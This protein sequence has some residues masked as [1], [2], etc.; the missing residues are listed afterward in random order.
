MSAEKPT[1]PPRSPASSD[2]ESEPYS[3]SSETS[4]RTLTTTKTEKSASAESSGTRV[5]LS[6]LSIASSKSAE[7]TASGVSSCSKSSKSTS[8]RMSSTESEGSD[9]AGPITV[10][11]DYRAHLTNVNNGSGLGLHYGEQLSDDILNT[12]V[13]KVQ[14]AAPEYLEGCLAVQAVQ[15]IPEEMP[16][17]I[18]GKHRILQI[19]L[20]SHRKH[21]ILAEWLP[22]DKHRG[23]G[24]YDSLAKK[25]DDFEAIL[26]N[27]CKSQFKRLFGHLYPEDN[28]IRL[29]FEAFQ[30]GQDDNWSCGLRTAAL[31][32]VKVFY[33]K[34]FRVGDVS[35]NLRVFHDV[36]QS[37]VETK[38]QI[39]EADLRID[40]W[41]KL[42]P[43]RK[44]HYVIFTFNR[45]NGDI[46]AVKQNFQPEWDSSFVDGDAEPAPIIA[47][48]ETVLSSAVEKMTLKD[49][50][51]EIP[52]AAVEAK[53]SS[54][55]DCHSERSDEEEEEE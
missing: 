29:R 53:T 40:D 54:D 8:A 32:A 33:R 23:V 46:N 6:G 4:V 27:S 3:D 50:E 16:K 38:H 14:S 34:P 26:N 11:D 28:N 19:I 35:F 51:E 25:W 13:D 44:L 15:L 39:T 2:D 31:F 41:F 30:E 47:N 17:L 21:F 42:L 22:T 9:S 10:D 12:F 48:A 45:A 1:T 49:T 18:P 52:V 7:S 5:S 43:P 20:D 37:V 36:L 55:S 24:I